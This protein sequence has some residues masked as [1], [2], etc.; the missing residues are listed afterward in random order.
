M[1]EDNADQRFPHHCEPKEYVSLE[2]LAGEQLWKVLALGLKPAV[3][4]CGFKSMIAELG[5]LSWRLDADNYEND[6]ELKK[7]REERGYSYSDRFI[8][9]S[10]ILVI[11]VLWRCLSS[12]KYEWMLTFSFLPLNLLDVCIDF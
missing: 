12:G 2:K 7:I 9:K 11:F 5:F 8:I 4:L 3:V 6:G 1:D 10:R